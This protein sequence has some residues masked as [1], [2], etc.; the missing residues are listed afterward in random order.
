MALTKQVRHH[1]L[2]STHT[3]R[4]SHAHVWWNSTCDSM[5]MDNTQ[6]PI[7]RKHPKDQ[8]YLR[9]FALVVLQASHNLGAKLCAA[10]NLRLSLSN[11]GGKQTVSRKS[12]RVRDMQQQKTNT[13]TLCMPHLELR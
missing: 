13:E 9:D 1:S 7:N 12:V 6:R 4:S 8:H 5:H 2:A 3:Q 10:L 11:T